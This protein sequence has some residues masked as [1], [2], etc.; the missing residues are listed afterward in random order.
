[1]TTQCPHHVHG[2]HLNLE[3]IPVL[4]DDIHKTG[5]LEEQTEPHPILSDSSLFVGFHRTGCRE[6][7]D[8]LTSVG[9]MVFK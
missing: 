1:M 3:G 8:V 2:Y 9:L 4:V 5:V 6:L 7:K